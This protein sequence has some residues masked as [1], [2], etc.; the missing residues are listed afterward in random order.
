[1]AFVVPVPFISVCGRNGF[2]KF[3]TNFA[4]ECLYSYVVRKMYEGRGKDGVALLAIVTM[5][6]SVCVV[7]PRG[8]RFNE[9][10]QKVEEGVAEQSKL[11]VQI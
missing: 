7:L 8:C 2:D 10:S 9:D 4:G 1:M 5:D 11:I 6:N 3:W